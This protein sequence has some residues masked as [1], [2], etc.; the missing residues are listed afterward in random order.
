MST[1]S[2][3]GYLGSVV[4]KTGSLFVAEGGEE[5]YR[6]STSSTIM[7][8]LTKTAVMGGIIAGSYYFGRD[9]IKPNGVV[10]KI[11]GKKPKNKAKVDGCVLHCY[12]HCPFSIKVE[13]VLAFLGVPYTRVL[14]G[15][16]DEEGPKSLP[17]KGKK[18]LPI[19]KYMGNNFISDSQKIIDMLEL[20]TVYRTIPPKTDRKD[21]EEWLIGLGLDRETLCRPR[22]IQMPVK[23]WADN[24][25][26]RHAKKKWGAMKDA[27]VRTADLL[28]KIN[29][30]LEKF[31]DKILFDEHS[32]NE[33]GF[34]MDDIL[35]LPDLRTLTCVQGIKWP[36]KVRK[37]LENAFE[38]THAELYFNY[39]V[40]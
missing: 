27:V 3:K 40:E 29:L 13:L 38:N 23:D 34:G 30:A 31:N 6:K 28:V 9:S 32:V 21:I 39:A 4:E 19:L 18:Q 7:S 1:K 17:V 22:L 37:Y 36:R 8:L 33:F 5:N 2:V 16:G 25:D 26:I 24:R 10:S 20:N 35:L 11:L 14:Y 15:F 12:D